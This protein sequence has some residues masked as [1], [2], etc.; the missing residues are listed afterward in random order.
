[1]AVRFILF[2]S[3]AISEHKYFTSDKVGSVASLATRLMYDGTMGI[4][5]WY[6]FS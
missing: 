1:M 2:W 4:Y 5:L 3:M 6:C